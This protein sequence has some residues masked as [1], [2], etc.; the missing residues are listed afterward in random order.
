MLALGCGNLQDLAD[1][2]QLRSRRREFFPNLILSLMQEPPRRINSANWEGA[3]SGI[4]GVALLDP[5]LATNANDVD[6]IL[7]ETIT[8]VR[9][10]VK[11]K[12]KG[13]V[14]SFFNNVAQG[15]AS[16]VVKTFGGN[17]EGVRDFF[18]EN[19]EFDHKFDSKLA[20]GIGD[21]GAVLLA[22]WATASTAR[23][24]ATTSGATEATAN[25]V[26]NMSG[27]SAATL[28]NAIIRYREAYD[29][30]I[31]FSGDVERAKEA[32]VDNLPA[33]AVDT[34]G[35]ILLT[36]ALVPASGWNKLS[37][38]AEKIAF[39]KTQLT[40]KNAAGQDIRIVCSAGN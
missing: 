5:E 2:S 23:L 19:P 8:Q 35:D 20:S 12:G 22:I 10:E 26:A 7:N 11:G 21:V 32:G 14:G 25:A 38:K 17:D 37:T 34:I 4:K 16:R 33:A 15:A 18:A 31:I 36:R 28:S 1:S 29:N 6:F 39:L 40:G 24:L 27:I 13:R 30:E 3:R 9:R